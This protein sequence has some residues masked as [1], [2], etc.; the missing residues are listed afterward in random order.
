[1]RILSQSGA[2]LRK[3]AVQMRESVLLTATSVPWAKSVGACASVKKYVP[4]SVLE[5]DP[6]HVF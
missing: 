1:M 4:L 5:E 3:R 2:I 6:R